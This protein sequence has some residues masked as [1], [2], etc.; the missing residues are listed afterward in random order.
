M[1]IA[2]VISTNEP[3]LV[4]NAFRFGSKALEGKHSV[5]VFLLARGVES[6]TIEDE[7][8]DVKKMMT[9]FSKKG[10]AILACGTCLKIRKRGGSALCPISSMQDLVDLT[11]Q[12]DR[13]LTFG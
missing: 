8:F 6:E 13:V 9:E 7:S 3:E 1:K 10:G 12:S 2:L 4:W 5:K 11:V